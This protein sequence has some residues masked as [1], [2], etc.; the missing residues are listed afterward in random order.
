ML[1]LTVSDH[2][3][4]QVEGEKILSNDSAATKYTGKLV[5]MVGSIEQE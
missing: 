3:A 4:K 2:Q 5:R 1:R